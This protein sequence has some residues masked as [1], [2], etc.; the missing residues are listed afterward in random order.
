M[1]ID[2]VDNR[3]QKPED[4]S[5]VEV[6][7]PEMRDDDVL[8]CF[9]VFNFD[10]DCFAYLGSDADGINITGQSQGVRSVRN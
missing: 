6:P 3:Y 8:V 1:L 7:L 9:P 4:Y 10:L 5:V 2:V